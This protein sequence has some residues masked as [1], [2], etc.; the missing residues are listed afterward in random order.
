MEIYLHPVIF[1][2]TK[3][4]ELRRCLSFC[5]RGETGRHAILRGWCLTGVGV[6][7][8]PR[9]LVK[10]SM[11]EMAVEPF[12]Y[13]YRA[14][15]ERDADDLSGDLDLKVKT[16]H[17]KLCKQLVASILQILFL[18]S[19]RSCLPIKTENQAYI[20]RLRYCSQVQ[21]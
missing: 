21:G 14:A 10:G 6:R 13:S 11:A 8:S 20:F 5:A 7:I 16:G 3:A 18:F 9:A 17:Q 15:S 1:A 12:F 2:P 19:D 4:L